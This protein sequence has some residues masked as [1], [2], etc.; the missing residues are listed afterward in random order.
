MKKYFGLLVLL[1]LLVTP[2]MAEKVYK[3]DEGLA[4]VAKNLSAK[5]PEGT[6]LVILD[7]KSAKPEASNYIVEQLTL[8]LLELGKVVVVD[9]QN[10][11]A[12]RSELSLQVSG[13]VS[14]ESAQ[15]LGALLG[16]QTLITGSFD[17]LRDKYRLSVKAVKVETS[18]IQYLSAMS[19]YSNADTEALFGRPS[20]AA[21]AVSTVGSAARRVAGFTG[22]FVC[23]MINPFVGIGSF[24]QGDSA[25][26]TTV[27][28]WEFVGVAGI[29]YGNY[30][31]AQ[32]QSNGTLVAASGGFVLGG[33]I[34]YS[35]IR[36][37]VYN[38]TPAVAAVL[39]NVRIE[40]TSADSVSLGYVIK[41]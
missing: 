29:A 41:Y 37:W 39:D 24:M 19:V 1:I 9:R 16:A 4:L 31:N 25:G 23:S 8:E 27:A 36:P 10:L 30:R 15:K 3:L 35:Y 13:D 21:A 12:I 34:I 7:I 6:K 40:T 38:R 26:G 32:D 33:A 18:E 5:L 28:F 2:A 11:D 14:D 17:L 20:S 22:R